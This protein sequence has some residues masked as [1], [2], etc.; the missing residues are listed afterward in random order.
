MVEKY[1]VQDGHNVTMECSV[2]CQGPE[3]A[4]IAWIDD[5]QGIT[6][7]SATERNET[8]PDNVTTI[9]SEVDVFVPNDALQLP[10]HTCS[11]RY[12]SYY[13]R[14]P[15]VIMEYYNYYYSR[16]ELYTHYDNVYT[17]HEWAS[18]RPN[19]SGQ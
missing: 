13:Q 8:K 3:T 17:P 19:V 11:V 15:P 18:P 2:D 5:D 4:Y 16:Y 7:T 9:I 12:Y 1:P 14:H 6:L 10:P